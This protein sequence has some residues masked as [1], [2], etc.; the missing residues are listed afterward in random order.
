PANTATPVPANTATA[1]PT[2]TPVPTAAATSPAAGQQVA[3]R[4]VSTAAGYDPATLNVALGDTVTWTN[5]DTAAPHTVTAQNGSFD[6]RFLAKRATRPFPPA[7]AGTFAYYCAFHPGMQ[8]T[9]VVAASGAA[10]TATAI[11][12][13]TDTPVPTNTAA[14]V[15]TD[16]PTALPTNTPTTLPANTATAVPTDTPI[17]LPTDTPTALPTATAAPTSPPAGHQLS[18]RIVSTT[19]GYDPPTLNVALGD[20]VTWTNSDTAAP[21]TVTAQNGSFDSGFLAKGATWS[22]TPAAAGTFAYYCAFHPGMLA[23]LVVAATGAA[24]PPTPTTPPTPTPAP[25]TPAAPPPPPP[26]PP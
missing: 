22:F 21:H 18:A 6:S 9:L 16:T 17:A 20:T 3:A 7:P 11:T 4:I 23:T 19:A 10:P 1:L 12:A 5:S 8:A 15:S 2:N 13:P 24:P 26:P 14:P 25:P